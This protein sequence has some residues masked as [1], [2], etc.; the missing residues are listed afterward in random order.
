[1][2]A[3]GETTRPEPLLVRSAVLQLVGPHHMTP[4]GPLLEPSW[5][6]WPA[7]QLPGRRTAT[8]HK[9]DVEITGADTAAESLT[10]SLP[11]SGRMKT[12]I[13]AWSRMRISTM[14]TAIFGRKFVA[15]GK[16]GPFPITTRRGM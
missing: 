1:M 15:A 9:R 6:G 3:A 4:E 16:K 14:I 7:T 13:G 10:I 5:V 11:T 8:A 12:T 2:I